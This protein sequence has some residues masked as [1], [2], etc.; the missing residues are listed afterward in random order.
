ME[1]TEVTETEEI[2]EAE[3]SLEAQKAAVEAETVKEAEA[4]TD[5]EESAEAEAVEEAKDAE[6]SG[7]AEEGAEAEAAG[8]SAEKEIK[9]SAKKKKTKKAKEEKDRPEEAAEN[10]DIPAPENPEAAI[11]AILFATGNSVKIERLCEVLHMSELEVHAAIDRMKKEYAEGKRGIQLTE[12]EDAVQLGTKGEY[13]EY[14]IRLARSPKR[15]SLSD[16]AIETLSIIAYK[17]PVTKA[18]IERIRGVSCEHALNRLLE[19]DLI[20]ELGRLD[21]PGRPL[22][23]GTTEQFLRS[24]GVSSLGELPTLSPELVED[25]RIQAEA[26]AEED[27]QLTL[28]V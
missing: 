28:D 17:Q 10:D 13:Y 19:Y 11:E 7:D 6:A 22:L 18:E 16:S 26:E 3:E 27:M 14:L 15:A 5:A 4:S 12:L 24:F 2:K 23:F 9:E 1:K 8:E 21:A 25:F 20:E